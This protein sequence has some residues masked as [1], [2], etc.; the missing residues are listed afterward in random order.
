MEIDKWCSG[1]KVRS[2]PWVDGKTIYFNVQYFAPG[3]SIAQPP[4][5]D[6][7]VYVTDNPAGQR[8]VC[9]FTDSLANHVAQ[10]QIAEG[11]KVVLTA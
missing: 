5:F 7:T 10:M 9:E 3:Q 6:K 1:Y 11:T 4:V 2:F 8:F